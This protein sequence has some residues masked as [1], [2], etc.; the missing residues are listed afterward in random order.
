MTEPSSPTLAAAGGAAWIT[1]VILTYLGVDYYALLGAWL[2]VLVTLGGQSSV[3]L[4]RTIVTVA[5]TSLGAGVVGQGLADILSMHSR[6]VVMFLS[7]LAG[8]G[9]QVIVQAAVEALVAR[10]KRVGEGGQP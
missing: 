10:I 4:V 6:P 8:A 5:I 9:F 2:G 3:G 1:T 7:L